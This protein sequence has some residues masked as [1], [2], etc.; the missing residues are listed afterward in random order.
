MAEMNEIIKLDKLP[1]LDMRSFKM[2]ITGAHREGI[3]NLPGK[4]QLF[5]EWSPETWLVTFRYSHGKRFRKLGVAVRKAD[6]NL[7]VGVMYWFVCPVTDRL[8]RKLFFVDGLLMSRFAMKKA[9]YPCQYLTAIDKVY[10]RNEKYQE[11]PYKRY[12][13]P[14]YRGKLTPYG[15]RLIRYDERWEASME[16]MDEMYIPKLLKMQR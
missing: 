15:K 2:V 6:T 4:V 16:V 10:H 3:A 8:C 9:R 14:Y 11:P 1:Y 12:G 13:K 5:F 7:G